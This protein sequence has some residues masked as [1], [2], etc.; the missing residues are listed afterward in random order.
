MI[1]DTYSEFLEKFEG[2]NPYELDHLSR[3]IHQK[4]K[5]INKRKELRKKDIQEMLIAA[6]QDIQLEFAEHRLEQAKLHLSQVKARIY[7]R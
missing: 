4:Y 5:M 3:A 7:K 6:M 2:L 1:R